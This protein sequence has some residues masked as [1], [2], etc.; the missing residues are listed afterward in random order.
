ML[1]PELY[2]CLAAWAAPPLRLQPHNK[3]DTASM[4][5]LLFLYLICS[6]SVLPSRARYAKLLTRSHAKKSTSIAGWARAHSGQVAAKSLTAML[7]TLGL[8]GTV[9]LLRIAKESA[10]TDEAN[11]IDE[12]IA[13]LLADDASTSSLRSYDYPYI[14]GGSLAIFAFVSYIIR[15]CIR[16]CRKSDN[17]ETKE[18]HEIECPLI[19][20][21]SSLP[22]DPAP[23]VVSEACVA[24]PERPLASGHAITIDYRCEFR[25]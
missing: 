10:S 16:R 18:N 25:T 12:M 24:G 2:G 13:S 23:V 11:T 4:K 20:A 3:S 9:K 5:G 8:V 7:S 6:F 15:R 21:V 14:A 1:L 19:Q 17:E 22:S